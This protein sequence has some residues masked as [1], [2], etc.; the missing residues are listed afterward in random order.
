MIKTKTVA[1]ALALTGL[2]GCEA[3]DPF[4]LFRQDFYEFGVGSPR[5]TQPFSSYPQ[6]DGTSVVIKV[7]MK[8]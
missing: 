6:S 8:I 4:D 1:L 7:G 2:A 5:N 3:A